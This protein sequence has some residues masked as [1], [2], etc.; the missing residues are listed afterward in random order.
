[1]HHKAPR[2]PLARLRRHPVETVPT[3]LG[4]TGQPPVPPV[5][6]LLHVDRVLLTGIHQMRTGSVKANLAH[7]Q[8][9]FQLPYLPERLVQKNSG[10]AA[11]NDLLV[12]IRLKTA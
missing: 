9:I 11:L 1:M 3:N 10:T 7:L 5:K 2:P 4:T 12:R 8:Q 6:P